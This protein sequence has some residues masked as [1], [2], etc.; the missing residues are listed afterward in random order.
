VPKRR[1]RTS[2]AVVD[3]LAAASAR[4][5]ELVER[6]RHDGIEPGGDTPDA[7]AARISR[8]IAL[9]RDLIRASNIRAE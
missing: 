6:F 2:K 5:A 3:K 1:T 7:F 9:W 8:E 4:A